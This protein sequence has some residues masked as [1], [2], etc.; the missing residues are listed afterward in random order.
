MKSACKVQFGQLNDKRFYFSIGILSLHLG[1]SYLEDLRK[2][3]N[4]YRK[5]HTVI[6]S[7]K[8]KFLKEEIKV[9]QKTRRLNILKQIYSQI[10]LL[11]ELNSYKICYF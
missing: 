4:K 1:H 6:Q 5:I 10:P 8:D 9:I 11:H 3:K 2:E 7:K